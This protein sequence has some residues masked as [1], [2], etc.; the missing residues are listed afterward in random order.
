MPGSAGYF[1][2]YYIARFLVFRFLVFMLSWRLYQFLLF[3]LPLPFA[4]VPA[5]GWGLFSALA[6]VSLGTYAYQFNLPANKRRKLP[7]S[8]EKS[9][10]VIIA[11]GAVQL[12][13]LLQCLI[14]W[15]LTSSPPHEGYF[16]F[17]QGIALL[18]FFTLTLLHVHS[19][20]R[21]ERV[22]WLVIIAAAFQALYGS[23]MVM[24][25]LEWSFFSEKW[26]YL[27][28]ATGTFVNRNHLAGY[29]EMSLALGI[30]FLL[31]SSTRYSGNWQQKLRQFIE[32]LLSPKVIMRLLLAVMVIGLVMT[33]S[34]MGNTAFFASL[35]ITGGLALLLMKN[36]SASTTILLSSLLIIDIA[37]VGT[38]FGVDKVAERLQKSST[39]HESRDEVSRDTFNMWLENP[40]LGTGASSYKYTYPAYKGDDVTSERLYD[41]AHN[42]YLQF[43]AEFGTLAFFC[44]AIAVAWVLFW[45]IQSMRLRRRP[46][47]QGLGFASAMGIIA[48]L[49]HSTVDF[50][51]QI[52]ANAFMFIFVLAIGCI[53][54]WADLPAKEKSNKESSL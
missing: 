46:I 14:Q 34:R 16:A 22:I 47:N 5:W 39:E 19:R 7:V 9:L 45:A 31:A 44:L 11:L 38:F 30:G 36:K 28:K 8:I 42:D 3:V 43:L 52:P 32:V 50:N 17:I 33:R 6:F 51:L 41:Y 35:M 23:I 2:A 15:L 21:A 1:F 48:I 13:V 18:A 27:G 25:G 10:P 20:S 4:G 37:I 24:T 53:A 54:R 40:I 29:L 12:I 26:A 49:I